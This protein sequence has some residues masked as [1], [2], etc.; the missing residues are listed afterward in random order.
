VQ[1]AVDCGSNSKLDPF[2]HVQPMKFMMQGICQTSLEFARVKPASVILAGQTDTLLVTV[3]CLMFTA[4]CTALHLVVHSQRHH[5][6]I[7]RSE[8]SF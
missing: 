4:V 2:R 5:D 1:T 7:V 3:A 6:V 8:F